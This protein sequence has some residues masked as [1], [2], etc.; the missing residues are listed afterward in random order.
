DT[1]IRQVVGLGEGGTADLLELLP[2]LTVPDLDPGEDAGDDDLPLEPGE[3]T[4]LRRQRDPALLVG[5][6]LAGTAEERTRRVELLGSPLRLLPHQVR[7]AQELLRCQHPEAATPT[8]GH[9][10]TI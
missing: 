8:L 9:H 4:Q 7:H 5:L 2:P 6:D 1:E 10:R 3:F